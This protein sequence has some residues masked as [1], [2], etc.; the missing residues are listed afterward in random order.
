[1]AY[2]SGL[3]PFVP[4][5]LV[6]RPSCFGVRRCNSIEVPGQTW[7]DSVFYKPEIT[8][9][10]AALS[11]PIFMSSLPR[12]LVVGRSGFAISCDD[13]RIMA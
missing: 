2:F 13:A 10:A 11:L 8:D 6:R 4:R 9:I 12:D 5:A 3:P 7:A 1:M